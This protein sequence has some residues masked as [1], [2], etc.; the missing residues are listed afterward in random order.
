MVSRSTV[1]GLALALAALAAALKM[2]GG[3]EA[4]VETRAT[5][6][7]D[8][9]RGPAS[10]A[11]SRD[12][13]PSVSL[14][15]RGGAWVFAPPDA[16]RADAGSADS[17]AVEA[18]LSALSRATVRDRVSPRQMRVRGLDAASYG[19]DSPRATVS[20]VLAGRSGVSVSFGDDAPGGGVFALV[21]DGA[22]V[23][24]VDR[25]AFD[26]VPSGGDAIRSRS[27]VVPEPGE[28]VALEIRRPGESAVRL[29]KESVSGA[30]RLASP[31]DFP[32]DAEAVGM[33][34][35]RL[36]GPSIHRFVRTPATNET[37]AAAAAA[38]LAHGLAPDEA[39]ASLAVWRQG[40]A[41][42]ET[43]FFG[44]EDPS[45]PG[46]VFAA[47]LQ[48]GIV[49]TVDKAVADAVETPVSGF[50][51]R[52]VFPFAIDD[53]TA[54][55]FGGPGRPE[56][57]LSRDRG[58]EWRFA[59]PSPAPADQ[60]AVEEF[61]SGPLSWR[62]A[63]VAPADGGA[64]APAALAPDSE[65]LVSFS[66]HGSEEPFGVSIRKVSPEGAK[67]AWTVSRS[68][69]G[70]PLVLLDGAADPASV[71][72]P[73]AA[74]AM[75]DRT[76]L[77]LPRAS[78]TGVTASGP[79]GEPLAVDPQAAQAVAAI[80]ADFTAESVLSV[81][82]ADSAAWGLLPPRAQWSVE[83][84]LLDRPVAIVQ[85]GASRPDGTA[86]VRVKGDPAVFAVSADAA[87]VLASCLTPSPSPTNERQNN[88]K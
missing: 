75:R 57:A 15:R 67:S 76:I 6:V 79:G 12:G 43:F 47:S 18:M 10:V 80:V 39:A 49:C 63:A 28:P 24:A 21:S 3:R 41:A 42:P 16:G 1:A 51:D 33:L 69:P 7:P 64:E 13:G 70:A 45:E 20:L 61:L 29:E 66:L 71:F 2:T 86:C 87:A 81:S 48:S 83:T 55:S 17:A 27:L 52:R 84:S 25:E 5:L 4:A 37:A 23:L 36:S 35:A 22:D 38:R 9:A 74:A 50:R 44:A 56:T 78:V 68:V 82:S 59:L 73:A 34:L 60:F 46:F 62:D 40:A 77:A 31:Y 65:L 72:S 58:G 26:S 14:V 88:K 32:A 19:L 11:I 30:W 85:L 53:V 54:F 8:A